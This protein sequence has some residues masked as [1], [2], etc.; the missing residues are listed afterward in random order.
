M[1]VSW[2]ASV[3][4]LVGPVLRKAYRVQVTGAHRVPRSGGVLLVANHDGIIDA[5]V[6]AAC[7]PRPVQVVTE[8]G[9]LGDAWARLTAVSGRIVLQEDAPQ[10]ALRAAVA[11]ARRGDAVGMFPEGSLPETAEPGLRPTG[12][13]AAYVQARSGVPVVCVAL[14][15]T[16][17]ARP[18][19]PP[20][21][22]AEIDLVFGQA[23]LPEPPA[24]PFRASA[25]LDLAER[26]RQRLADHLAEASA[27]TGRTDV[28]RIAAPGD[29]GPS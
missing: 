5:T 11:A 2:P 4:N 8:P 19:D 3:R 7:G 6:L 28:P 17:G 29:N 9:A 12:P 21:P 24:D 23:F 22:G 25:L 15:G 10:S 13:G 27:R 18:T 1:R 14:L 20:S 26:I 16:H